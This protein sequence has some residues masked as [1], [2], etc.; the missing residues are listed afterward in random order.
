MSLYCLAIIPVRGGSKGISRKNARLLNGSPLLSYAI[1]A[2]IDADCFSEIVVSTDD[3][4]LEYLAAGYGAKVTRRPPE[5]ARDHV[6]L[7]E[8]IVD[9]VAT[10]EREAGKTVDYVATIQAT[11]PLLTPATIRKAVKKCIKKKLDTVVSVVEDTHLGWR[12]N[13]SND[14]VPDYEERL[15][16]QFLP[17]HYRETGGIVVCNRSQI[18]AGT[19]FGKNIDAVRLDKK[20]AVDIDDRFDWWLAEKQLQRKSIVLRVEGYD[21]IGLGH[22]YRCLT[23]ADSM[24]DHDVHFVVSHKSAMGIKLIKSRFYE[25]V[26]FKDAARELA[27]I[28]SCAPDVVVNDILDTKAAYV[29]ALK[30]AGYKVVNFEDQG[31][32]HKLADRVINAMYAETDGKSGIYGGPEYVC[33][34]DEFYSAKP[35]EIR[36]NVKNVLVLFGG[37]DPSNLTL[38]VTGWLTRT[39]YKNRI[40]VVVGPG[41]RRTRGLEELSRKHPRISVVSNTKI[42][43]KYMGAADLAV[44]SAGRTVF[45]LATLGI[46]MVVLCQ[47]SRERRHTFARESAGVVNLGDGKS[48]KYE[49][50]RR[51]FLKLLDSPET[52]KEMHESLLKYKFKD[53]IRNVWRLILSA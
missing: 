45:E 49:T 47:N 32:G 27:A 33:L 46:P 38:K 43:T 13:D 30:N 42:I 44:T 6:G 17:K 39:G 9:A 4:E 37:T 31:S 21:D 7:D 18:D 23:L 41:Y 36:E 12:L 51:L 16:R 48:V 2:A 53:G 19:R 34:R 3:D 10:M 22:V 52:R 11:S 15:N 8:V 25:V 14:L 5:L 29:R 50:F 40:T 24:L 26:S 20:E 1:K 28:E 35:I